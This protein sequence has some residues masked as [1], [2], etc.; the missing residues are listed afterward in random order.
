MTLAPTSASSTTDSARAQRVFAAVTAAETRGVI[1]SPLPWIGAAVSVAMAYQQMAPLLPMIP[2][3]DGIAYGASFVLQAT[4]M[5]TGAL[6]VLR[7]RDPA[8][9]SLIRLGRIGWS[10]TIAARVVAA[11]IGGAVVWCGYLLVCLGI[12]AARG[13]RGTPFVSLTVDGLLA[14]S[15]SAVLGVVLALVVRRRVAPCLIVPAVYAVGLWWFGWWLG[16]IRTLFG[17]AGWFAP[18]SRVP[19]ESVDLGFMPAIFT[20]HTFYLLGLIAA[21]AGVAVGVAASGNAVGRPKR[22]V[23]AV[24]VILTVVGVAIAASVGVRMAQIPPY[25]L[26]VSADP[27]SWV[28]E[29]AKPPVDGSQPAPF[30]YLN[31]GKATLC[32]EHDGFTACVYPDYGADVAAKVATAMSVEFQPV[33]MVPDAPRAIRMVP[34]MDG[35][36]AGRHDLL[37]LEDRY[38]LNPDGSF[39]GG[40][41]TR[42]YTNCLFGTDADLVHMPAASAITLWIQMQTGQQHLAQVQEAISQFEADPVVCPPS[43]TCAATYFVINVPFSRWQLD[44]AK[45]A[46]ALDRLPDAQVQQALIKVWNRLPTMT[47]DELLAACRA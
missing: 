20:T 7:D 41:I 3:D 47:I 38:A 2:G 22:S 5:L 29:P 12:S 32:R 10:G 46:V 25:V 17:A 16:A 45:A 31:D 4:M 40:W 34:D 37:L 21:F 8:M 13:G 43:L 27:A 18:L 6:L 39:F 9:H 44:A 26:A 23:R 1:R 14:T 19:A 30:V 28:P 33:R 24:P 15:L 36:C 42:F 11:V 35:G